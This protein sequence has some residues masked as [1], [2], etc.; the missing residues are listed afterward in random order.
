MKWNKA[1]RQAKNFFFFSLSH[2]FTLE[3][4]VVLTWVLVSHT[5]SDFDK[6]ISLFVRKGGGLFLFLN[7]WQISAMLMYKEFLQL[8][9]FTF[10]LRVEFRCHITHVWLTSK[11]PRNLFFFDICKN[12]TGTHQCLSKFKFVFWCQKWPFVT[13]IYQ[14]QYLLSLTII[15]STVSHNSCHLL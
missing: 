10:S 2:L 13:Q 4:T 1:Y 11:I 3:G 5:T 12:L 8:S 7:V 14:N 9:L 6:R 15:T